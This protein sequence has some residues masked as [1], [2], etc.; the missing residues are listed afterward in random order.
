MSW[1]SFSR[2]LREF[3]FAPYRRTLARAAREE[4]DFFL[5][6]LLGEALGVPNPLA[7]ETLELW[8]HLRADLHAWH[9]RMGMERS[10]FDHLG[11]C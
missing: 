5:L 3:Y 11:C 6:I 4:D 8:P 9:L 1:Q 10:P 2:A 7:Y